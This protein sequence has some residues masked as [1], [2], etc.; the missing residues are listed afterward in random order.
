MKLVDQNDSG[1]SKLEEAYGVCCLRKLKLGVLMYKDDF[2][3]FCISKPFYYISQELNYTVDTTCF[4]SG[5]LDNHQA[6]KFY[7]PDWFQ[8][9]FL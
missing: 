5:G 8:A 6:T 2:D 3:N 7:Y 1:V 9:L 4:M